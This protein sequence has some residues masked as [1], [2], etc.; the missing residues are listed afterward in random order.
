M[1]ALDASGVS[2][3]EGRRVGA[4][5]SRFLK[6]G[7]GP[8]ASTRRLRLRPRFRRHLFSGRAKSC[9][10]LARASARADMPSR[11]GG[12]LP[13]HCKQARQ[14]NEC[15]V[16][17]TVPRLHFS[18]LLRLKASIPSSSTF[19]ATGANE[20]DQ[21]KSRDVATSGVLQAQSHGRSLLRHGAR[22]GTP[23]AFRSGC[24]CGTA[25]GEHD[26]AV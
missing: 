11:K 21:K 3:R 5:G 1:I 18:I 14:Q 10:Y 12:E 16:H 17:A 4:V 6:G 15:R 25:L 20:G 9:L 24:P 13:A 26:V 2:P 22:R 7:A 19:P 8:T 23:H